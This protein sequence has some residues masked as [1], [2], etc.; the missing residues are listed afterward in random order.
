ME[1]RTVDALPLVAADHAAVRC[2][3]A[4]ELSKK[5]WVAAVNTPRPAV[6]VAAAWCRDL[7]LAQFI[8]DLLDRHVAQLDQGS[9][10]AEIAALRMLIPG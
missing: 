5:S 7:P 6:P 3:L 1:A 8:S 10:F 4:I 2:L 9:F